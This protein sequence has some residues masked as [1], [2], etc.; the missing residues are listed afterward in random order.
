MKS[1]NIKRFTVATDKKVAAKIKKE[2]N[3]QRRSI[4]AHAGTI[5]ESHYSSKESK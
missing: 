5:L 3:F 4:A 1:V 2:A